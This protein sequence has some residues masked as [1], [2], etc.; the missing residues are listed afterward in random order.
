M[1]G[2]R[3]PIHWATAVDRCKLRAGLCGANGAHF[4]IR[5]Y[6]SQLQPC[7]HS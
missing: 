2:N 1:A 3:Y 5:K 6:S 7:L 4:S